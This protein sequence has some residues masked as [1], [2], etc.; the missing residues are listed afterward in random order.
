M[1]KFEIPEGRKS[2]KGK[3]GV[4]VCRLQSID[5]QDLEVLPVTRRR[6]LIENGTVADGNLYMNQERGE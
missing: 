6:K 3:N 2:E 5:V 4:P 1:G